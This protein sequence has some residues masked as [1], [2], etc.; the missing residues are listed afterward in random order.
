MNKVQGQYASALYQMGDAMKGIPPHWDAYIT[1]DDVDAVTKKAASNGGTIVKEPFDVMDVGRMSVIKDPTGAMFCL[2][3]AKKHIG[4][5]ILQEP[6]SITFNELYTNDVDRAG[7][8]TRR[9]SA[10]RRAR[11]TWGRWGLTRSSSG[12]APR[13]TPAG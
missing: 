12:Q 6:G 5:G 13:R 1:V 2:W 10:G 4:A 7:S 9:P 8:S 3:T 11:S